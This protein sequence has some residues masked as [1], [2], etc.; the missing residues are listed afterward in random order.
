MQTTFSFFLI[1]TKTFLVAVGFSWHSGWVKHQGHS[2]SY[3]A[4]GAVNPSGSAAELDRE[5]EHK[6][7]L[8][9]HEDSADNYK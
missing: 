6:N 5:G 1:K 4:A 9:Q 8:L 7:S 3:H 2:A